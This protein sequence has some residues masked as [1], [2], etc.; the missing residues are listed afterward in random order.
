MNI[1]AETSDK[2]L[3]DNNSKQ[4]DSLQYQSWGHR[5]FQVISPRNAAFRTSFLPIS[6]DQ[7]QQDE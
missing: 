5:N 7:N 4:N 3:S 1:S 2:N 6:G